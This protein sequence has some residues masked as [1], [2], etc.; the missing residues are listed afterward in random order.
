[1]SPYP[2]EYD[3]DEFDDDEWQ[4]EQ[5]AVG[6]D[7]NPL[8]DV[9]DA[10]DWDEFCDDEWQEEQQPC[11]ANVFQTH[12][13]EEDWD[14]DLEDDWE[15]DWADMQPVAPTEYVPD[16]MFL[17]F[18]TWY[19]RLDYRPWTVTL[20][21]SN[22]KG[23]APV[24][25]F[26]GAQTK[27]DTKR[28]VS[29]KDP[30]DTKLLTFH[31]AKA[32]PPNVTLSD[33]E[34]FSV[35]VL[36]GEDVDPPS[37]HLGTPYISAP[38]RSVHVLASGGANGAAYLIAIT[39]GTDQP[40]HVTLTVKGVLS[41]A[42]INLIAGLVGTSHEQDWDEECADEWWLEEQ[43]VQPTAITSIQYEWEL[44]DEFCEDDW[45]EEQQPVG[46][47]APPAQTQ[48]EW[49]WGDDAALNF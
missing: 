33:V 18:T 42:G 30:S 49:E 3:W 32:L 40:G 8:L 10:W 43:P 38:G 36:S 1:M 25:S 14:A 16:C 48:D 45:I 22:T 2:D 26:Q 19:L 17:P 6:R 37:L 23:E 28:Y 46:P 29:H 44:W 39:C 15:D 34:E 12:P 5:Q 9:E 31:V 35:A 7:H 21:F 24:Q 41:I 13:L 4:E 11:V 20:P 47:N 27:L